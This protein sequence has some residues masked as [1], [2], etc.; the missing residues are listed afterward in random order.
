ML[1][2]AHFSDTH[3]GGHESAEERSA[4]VLDHLAG[5]RPGPDVVLITG[6]IA[7]HGTADEYAAADHVLG[8]WPGPA[9]M[10]F[11]PGNHDVREEYAA[12]RRRPAEGPV[13][14]AH[15]VA[16]HLFLML[17]SLVPAPPGE[18]FDHGYLEKETLAWLDKRLAAREPGEHA[19][20]CMHHPPVDIHI[21]LMDPIKLANADQ[22]AVVLERHEDVVAVL[23]GHAHTACASTFAGLPVLVGGGAASTV[24]LDAEPLPLV[25]HELGPTFA[26]HLLGDD[27]NLV[28]HWR[29]L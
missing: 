5:I 13:N 23:V 8:S 26:V 17:D 1:V 29:T 3:F 16:G 27:G 24:T 10:L 21:S 19:F 6:D 25:T 28:T 15:R 20:V 7:D 11:C 2:I 12:F 9:P 18:R 22:L 4:R 14:E